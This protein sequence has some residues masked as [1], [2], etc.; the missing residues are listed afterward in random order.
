MRA[1]IGHAAISNIRFTDFDRVELFERRSFIFMKVCSLDEPAQV[2]GLY[3]IVV[4]TAFLQAGFLMAVQGFADRQSQFF[5]IREL[6]VALGE[7][8]K[9]PRSEVADD[10]AKAM[11]TW[12][13]GRS[14]KS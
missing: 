6:P 10:L 1:T 8:R 2:C 5:P 12:M 14:D 13:H 3:D 4:A 11:S 9:A 7:I